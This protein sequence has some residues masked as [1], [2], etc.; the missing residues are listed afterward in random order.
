MI[1]CRGGI[2]G[3]LPTRSFHRDGESS[4][5]ARLCALAFEPFIKTLFGKRFSAKA[6]V[7]TLQKINLANISKS[8]VMIPDHS[9][10]PLNSADYGFLAVVEHFAVK[11]PIT[12]SQAT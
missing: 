6:H 10:V 4:V 5:F 2:V 7:C 11:A 12:A 3:E 1:D 9:S 8:K